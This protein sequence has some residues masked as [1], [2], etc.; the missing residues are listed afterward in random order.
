MQL[1]RNAT[2]L[3]L[4]LLHHARGEPLE[5][6]AAT[7]ELLEPE[8]HDADPHAQ[9]EDDVE[10]VAPRIPRAFGSQNR[11]IEMV[12]APGEQNGREHGRAARTRSAP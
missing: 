2:P 7:I 3:L 11:I 4:V 6:L 9:H 10:V 5:V 1:E 8:D 12:H